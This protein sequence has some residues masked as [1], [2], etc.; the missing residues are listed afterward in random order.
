MFR[1]ASLS[2]TFHRQWSGCSATSLSGIGRMGRPA[3]GRPS[4]LA[5]SHPSTGPGSATFSSRPA[6]PARQLASR[7]AGRRGTL[8]R[9]TARGTST[10]SPV[11]FAL[12]LAST[13]GAVSSELRPGGPW[14]STVAVPVDVVPGGF[15]GSGLFTRNGAVDAGFQAVIDKE[16]DQLGGVGRVVSGEDALAEVRVR[17]GAAMVRSDTKDMNQSLVY[18][19]VP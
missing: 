18:G 6:R 11:S 13:R 14:V 17:W 1:D 8:T 2:N 9:T 7:L 16:V 12:S 15:H 4:S 10:T 3:I 19:K 5:W